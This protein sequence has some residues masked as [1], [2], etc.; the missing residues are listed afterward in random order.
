MKIRMI[1]A[2]LLILASLL[3]IFPQATS[4]QEAKIEL[5]TPYT[6]LEGVS[7][8]SFEFEIALNYTGTEA[9][10]FN[11]VATGPKDWTTYVT[12]S[13]PKDQR[14]LD[15]RLEPAKPGE[16]AYGPKVDVASAPPAWLLPEPG[17][18]KVTLEVSSGEISSTIDLTA[19]VTARYDMTLTT[20]SGLLNTTATAGKDNHFAIVVSNTGSAALDNITFSPQTPS[21]WTIVFSPDKVDSLPAGAS[22]TVDLNIRPPSKAIAGDYGFLITTTSK[23]GTSKDI[24]IRV[25]VETP[26]IWGWVGVIIILLVIAGVG[27]VFMRFSRR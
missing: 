2:L 27:F 19:V 4:A 21:G 9:R 10:V 26:S 7:G 6:K 1:S 5:T 20:P 12:P 3:L 13:Y 14:I 22:K 8:A 25:T 23:Q 11:L 17:E 24:N 16:A 15:I 18:Y